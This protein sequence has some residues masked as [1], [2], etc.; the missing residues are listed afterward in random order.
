MKVIGEEGTSIADYIEYLKGDFL[1]AVYLQQNAFD[2]VDEATSQERQAYVVDFIYRNIIG[3]EFAF[4]DKDTA[5]KFFQSL[6]QLFKGWNSA[7]W[8]SDEF[9]SIE[10]EMRGMI[11]PHIKTEEQIDA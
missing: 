4:P 5:L 3:R 7:A 8:G 11:Q 2:A 10:E 1:D 6:R 9:A